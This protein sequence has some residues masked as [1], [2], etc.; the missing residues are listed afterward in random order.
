MDRINKYLKLRSEL[1]LMVGRKLTKTSG[2]SSTIK[3]DN[4]GTRQAVTGMSQ[5][6]IAPNIGKQSLRI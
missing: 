4:L 6:E 2:L 3:M 1:S 5:V